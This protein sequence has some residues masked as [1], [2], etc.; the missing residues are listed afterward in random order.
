MSRDMTTATAAQFGAARL[1]PLV[2]AQADFDTGAL[3][4]WSGVGP[5][6]WDGETWTGAGTLLSIEAIEETEGMKAVGTAFQLAGADAA[7]LTLAEEEDYQGRRVRIWVGALDDA[8]VVVVDP[9]QIFTGF[10]D[11]MEPEEGGE[12]CIIRCTAENH[13]VALE[14]P[15]GRVYTAEDQKMDYPNDT[16]FDEVAGLQNREITLK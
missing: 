7:L 16:F 12:T 3:R 9:V 4:L 14:R 1:R 6:T 13:L 8:G 2:L 5:I 15:T 10:L 11:V